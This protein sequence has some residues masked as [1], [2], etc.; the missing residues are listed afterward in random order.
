MTGFD[1]AADFAFASAVAFAFAAPC[2]LGGTAASFS[3]ERG[4]ALPRLTRIGGI[5]FFATGS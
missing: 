5:A 3:F 2:A 1:I 4:R